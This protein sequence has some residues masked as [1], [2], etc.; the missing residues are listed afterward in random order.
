M[1]PDRDALYA[2]PARTRRPGIAPVC[3]PRSKIGV[4]GDER[5]LV[6][7]DALHEAA[8]AGRHVVDEL[9]LVRAAAPSKSIRL[10]SARR[11]GASRPRSVKPKKS[12]VSL[13]CRLTRSSSGRRGPR[14]RSRPQCASMKLGRPASTIEVQC[15]PPSL[16]PEQARRIVQHLADRLMVAGDVVHHREVEIPVVGLGDVVVGHLVGRTALA[17][18]DRGDALLRRRLVVRRIAHDEEL[19]PAAGDEPG[20]TAQAW[21]LRRRTAVSARI[22]RRHLGVAQPPALLGDR[23]AFELLVAR[24]H[25]E[26]IERGADAHHARRSAGRRSA[27]SAAG[28]RRAP[29]ARPSIR[30]RQRSG[31]S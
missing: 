29:R 27:R 25:R 4:S 21:R 17:R 26:R 23:Q 15:A 7:V 20:G 11:P 5:R 9:G 2:W 31:S 1:T 28:P 16:K 8:A 6:A 13:V 3:A 14:L 30:R 19:V 12:A 10:T 24:P 22:W 18:G